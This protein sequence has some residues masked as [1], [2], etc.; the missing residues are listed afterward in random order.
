MEDK[1]NFL[2]LWCW[3]SNLLVNIQVRGTIKEEDKRNRS[4]LVLIW[5]EKKNGG[6]QYR[7]VKRGVKERNR[8]AQQNQ[9]ELE[10]KESRG[11]AFRTKK[12][13]S[14]TYERK[15]KRAKEKLLLASW[16][17]CQTQS[18]SG[19]AALLVSQ[20]PAHNGG[21]PGPPHLS[22][23]ICILQDRPESKGAAWRDD[24]APQM[25]KFS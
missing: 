14:F 8:K 10:E 25:F 3:G 20:A 23:Q 12:R 7:N 11:G 22:L 17:Q 1:S 15:K 24:N 5:G 21:E 19:L 18:V 16:T 13:L 9:G 6:S 2:M 4:P